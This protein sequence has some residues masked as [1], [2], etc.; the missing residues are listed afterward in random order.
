MIKVMGSGK[1]K[2]RR[3]QSVA[4]APQV[5]SSL[6]EVPGAQEWRIGGKPDGLLHRVDGPARIYNGMFGAGGTSEWYQNGKMHL[7]DG[8]AGEYADGTKYWM[9][10][11]ELHRADGPAI[12]RG[13]GLSDVW[14]VHGVRTTEE[15][16]LELMMKDD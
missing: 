12:E 2:S 14:I 6:V 15:G 4:A 9:Q 11:G 5:E 16:A 1:G 10:N 13:D 3:T 7:E 8:P